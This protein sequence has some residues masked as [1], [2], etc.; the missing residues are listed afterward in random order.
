MKYKTRVKR[1]RGEVEVQLTLTFT[2]EELDGVDR[3]SDDIHMSVDTIKQ[4]DSQLSLAYAR[5][6]CYWVELYNMRNEPH[7]APH[8]MQCVERR[9]AINNRPRRKKRG[10]KTGKIKRVRS[11]R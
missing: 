9:N 3:I 8:L 11:N 10:S 2:Q 1:S 7:M 5:S 6:M 4:H